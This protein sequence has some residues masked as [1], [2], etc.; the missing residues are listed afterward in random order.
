LF[1]TTTTF[2]YYQKQASTLVFEDGSS[3]PPTP[4]TTVEN[5]LGASVLGFEAPY[6]FNN[7]IVFLLFYN[8]YFILYII[9]ASG[10]S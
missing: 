1:S 9:F 7:I 5:E 2:Y 4:F 10:H 6:F 8:I 3:P